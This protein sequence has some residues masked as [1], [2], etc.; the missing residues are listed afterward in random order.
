MI[1]RVTRG[2]RN[3]RW[4]IMIELGPVTVILNGIIYRFSIRAG[5]AFDVAVWERK[6][7]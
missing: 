1:R 5:R 2:E 7:V 4:P 3:G 6:D